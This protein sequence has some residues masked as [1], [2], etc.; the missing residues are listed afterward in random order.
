MSQYRIEIKWAIINAVVSM[1][2]FLGERIA[3]FHGKY[4]SEQANISLLLFFP[5]I[6]IYFLGCI[7]KKRNF[8]KGDMTYLQ[9]FLF[10]LRLTVYILILTPFTQFIS[11]YVISPDFFNRMIDYSVQAGS[12]T[13]D[14][15]KRQFSYGNFLFIS[16]LSEIITGVPIAAFVPIWTKSAKERI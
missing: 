10:G 12:L 13:M 15:A 1:L 16:I 11:S 8:Y 7:D 3:G 9:G 4:L 2:W 14:Q 5:I 6:I